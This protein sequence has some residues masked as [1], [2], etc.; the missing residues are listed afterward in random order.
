MVGYLGAPGPALY[1]GPH[2]SAACRLLQLTHSAVSC[3][4]LDVNEM[5]QS[6]L[7]LINEKIQF[8]PMQKNS[9]VTD[10]ASST[11]KTASGRKETGSREKQRMKILSLSAS[12]FLDPHLGSGKTR[13][14]WTSGLR[15][16]GHEVDILQP[17]D[18]EWWPALKI[19][20]GTALPLE[21]F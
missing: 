19:G 16:L 18:V 9:P 7:H 5:V 10:L 3:T 20:A 8:P 1:H 15:E 14:Q 12:V 21:R 13:L 17:S 6:I 11:F 2:D 4:S